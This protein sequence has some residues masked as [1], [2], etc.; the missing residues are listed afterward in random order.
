[1]WQLVVTSPDKEPRVVA[2]HPGKLTPGRASTNDVVIEDVSASRTHAEI[3]LDGLTNTLAL[4]DLN[5]TN[6]TYVNRQRVTG[7]CQLHPDDLIRIGMVVIHVSHRT[8]PMQPS[9]G[10]SGTHHFT[11]E[12]V[13]KSV[14]EHSLLI[15]EI[16]QKLNTILDVPAAVQ[17]VTTILERAMGV[18]ACEMLLREDLQRLT[19]SDLP[20]PLARKALQN[21]TAEVAP[22]R[23]FVPIS[24]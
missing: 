20:D 16:A 14:E 22:T 5:S 23:I 2:V 18:D 1:M 10:A 11:R 24:D 15:A 7:S 8:S 6:G 19:T 12:L 4:T 9:S 3:F 21:K 17:Q 13:L